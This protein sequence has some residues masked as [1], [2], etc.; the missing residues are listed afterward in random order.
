M[1]FV[2]RQLHVI[3][4][5]HSSPKCRTFRDHVRE[6]IHYY[7]ASSIAVVVFVEGLY[8]RAVVCFINVAQKSIQICDFILFRIYLL[9]QMVN[10]FT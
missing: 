10:K 1:I 2:F 3:D 9:L 5:V 8:Q 7:D 6:F 4:V